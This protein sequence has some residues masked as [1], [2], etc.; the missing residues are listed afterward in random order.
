MKRVFIE[1][2]AVSET[3]GY[4]LIFGIVLTCIA[5]ILLVG[6]SMLDTAK[7]QNNFKS[8]EQG[9]TVLSSDMKQVALEGTPVK[10]T[11]IHMEGGSIA[12]Y[13]ASNELIVK[14]NGV[15]EYDNYTGNITF[16]SS[17]DPSIISIENGGLWE[18]TNINSSDIVVL[19]PRIYYIPQTKTLI[20]N[21][22]RL[23]GNMS[24]IGG[25]ATVDINLQYSTTNVYSYSVPAG[26]M[27]ITFNTAYPRAWSRFLIDDNV[28]APAGAT[29]LTALD[30]NSFTVNV[31][32]PQVSN[33]IISEHWINASIG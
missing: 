18:M 10:T 5:F 27:T 8:M 24:A 9:L 26:S 28:L 33:L 3:L 6:N 30:N 11:R 1:D 31:N 13:N 12:N 23:G 32:Q 20:M 22:I 21:V 4:I 17:T 15:T 7:S 19:K 14:F 25:S 29:T 2:E 16:Q